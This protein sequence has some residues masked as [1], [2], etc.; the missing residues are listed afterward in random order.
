M[1]ENNSVIYELNS[2]VGWITLNVP[3]RGNVVNNDNLPLIKQFIDESNSNPDCRVIVLQGRDGVFSRGMDFM[4]LIRNAKGGEIKNE[5]TDP[6]KEAVLAIRNS[7]KPVIGIIDGDVLACG[8]G[9]ALSCDIIIS[10]DKSIFGLSEVLF[11]IIPA[12]VYPFLLERVSYKHARYMVLSSKRFN[13]EDALRMGLIDELVPQE[14]LNKT[15][16]DTIKRILYSSPDALALVKRYSDKLTD[17]KIVDAVNFAQRQLTE[18]L[19]VE[20]NVNTIKA[21]TEGEKAPWAVS[22]KPAKK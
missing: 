2:Y 15:V 19:N 3:E 16:K 9:L 6:Y 8:M 13:A 17:N 12:F 7:A 5:F 14:N 18:L 22:Y 10:S 4:N 21:F 1:S 20:A 11:G